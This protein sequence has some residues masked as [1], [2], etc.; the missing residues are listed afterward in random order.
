MPVFAMRGKLK[1]LS[2][3][4][5]QYFTTVRIFTIL[6]LISYLWFKAAGE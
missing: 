4:C 3:S 2:Y 6:S 5:L 1:Q